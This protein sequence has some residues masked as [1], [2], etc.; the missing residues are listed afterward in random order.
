MLKRVRSKAMRDS[1]TKYPTLSLLRQK[2]LGYGLSL[3]DVARST[4]MATSVIYRIEEPGTGASLHNLQALADYYNVSPETILKWSN[5][6]VR[7]KETG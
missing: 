6:H 4:G 5:T 1:L 7:E 3:L 2:R